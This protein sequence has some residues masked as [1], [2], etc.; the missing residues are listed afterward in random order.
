MPG[1]VVVNPA[2][3]IQEVSKSFGGVEAVRR[4]SFDIPEASIIGLIG[5]NG[6]GKTS[7]FNI[8]SGLLR[9]DSGRVFFRG[10]DISGVPTH[11]LFHAGLVRTFQLPHEFAAMTTIENLMVPPPGQS[12]EHIFGACLRPFTVRREERALAARADEVLALLRLERVR[13][14]RAGNLSGGQ[15]KLLELGRA[16]MSGATVMLLDEPAAGV[17]RGLLSILG[18]AIRRLN[19]EQG[20]TFCIVEHDMAFIR[21]MCHSVVLMADG[22]A[23]VRGSMDRIM[24]DPRVLDAYLG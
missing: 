3:S 20:C 19:A 17:N 6:A 16:M 8:I 15:K 14:E 12:G 1:A 23:L 24:S 18:D 4:C 10:R 13:D 11:R 22:E 5:P 2:L 7:L 21:E 9:P